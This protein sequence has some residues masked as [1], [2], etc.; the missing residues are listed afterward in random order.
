MKK[1]LIALSIFALIGSS[2]SYAAVEQVKV[3]GDI[4]MQGINRNLSMG[5]IFTETTDWATYKTKDQENFLLSQVRLRVDAD[6]TENVSGVVRLL[7]ERIW[8][9]EGD[10]S[11]HDVVTYKDDSTNVTLDLAYIKLAEFF[12]QPLTVIVGR[13]NLRY[14]NAMVIGDPDTNQTTYKKGAR[15]AGDLSKRK[16]FD[17]LRTISDLSPFLNLAITAESFYAKVYEGDT[18]RNDDATV[19]GDQLAY[20]W[21]G[22]NGI[23]EAYY[24]GSH[25]ARDLTEM[26]QIYVDKQPKENQSDV[27][28]FGMRYQFDPNENITLGGE[29]A[30]QFGNVFCDRDNDGKLDSYTRLSAWAGQAT[31]EYR[32]LNKFKPKFGLS[33]SYFSGDENP[34]SIASSGDKRP[35]RQHAW[36]PMYE[37]Q[38]PAEIINI[39]MAQSN[40]QYGK[41]TT[42][43]MPRE[44]LTVGLIYCHARLAQ[45]HGFS[46]YY[47]RRGPAFLN[48]YIVKQSAKHFGDEV[49]I[50]GIY[51]YT[52]DVQFKL[53]GAVF[54]PGPFFSN[55]NDKTAYSVR[56]GVSLNF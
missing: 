14:G 16:S 32:M 8:G 52:E 47:P 29:G 5:S 25:V 37:D 23:T 54:A 17:S 3:S 44:D 42:S 2:I 13:Q 10:D 51:D 33:Y 38:T 39:L 48:K 46:Y 45:S 19:W 55:E 15:E 36:D 28:C 7:N 26:N 53:V 35:Q 24:F 41:F 6:L 9:E 43:F 56:G 27:N 21:A 50:Y 12:I 11:T 49:D 34:T 20:Q 18:N 4:E 1:L 40:A 30:L 22:Y 31:A